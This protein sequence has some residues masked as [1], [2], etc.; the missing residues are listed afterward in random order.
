ME[1]VLNAMSPPG[2]EAGVL[3]ENA[4]EEV[5]PPPVFAFMFIPAFRLMP[6]LPAPPEPEP[7]MN[8]LDGMTGGF[9]R[10]RALCEGVLL[11][12]VPKPVVMLGELNILRTACAYQCSDGGS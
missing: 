2:P 3:S 11:P 8:V 5:A 4:G 9:G 12:S 1:P 6:I 7:D 10:P